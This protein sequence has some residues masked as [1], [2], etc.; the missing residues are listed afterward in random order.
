MEHRLT[1]P[2]EAPRMAPLGR[3]PVFAVAQLAL[4][5]G[6][7]WTWLATAG[8]RPGVL[9]ALVCTAPA[10]LALRLGATSQADRQQYVAR[11]LACAAMLPILLMMWAGAQDTPAPTPEMAPWVRHPWIFFTTFAVL[12]ATI[13]VAAIAWL[14]RAVTRVEAARHAAWVP[15]AVLAQRLQ[16]LAAA[17]VPCTVTA[18]ERPGEWTVALRLAAAER[19]HRVLLKIDEPGRTVRVRERL[20]ASGAAPCGC[21][22]A[23][24]RTL[25]EPICDPTRPEAQKISSRVAQATMIDP[26]RLQAT[27]LVLRDGIAE[28][29]AQAPSATAP[30]PDAVV[31]LLC[32]LVTRSGY[33]WQP[34]L[35]LG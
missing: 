10:V 8:A 13:F 4:M 20:G 21:E 19:S 11:L 2:G 18:G 34:L 15:A 30:D 3:I 29:A 9:E 27:R 32:A 26:A 6:L 23:S 1:M 25:G 28:P 12:H 22:E 35:G 24:L 7:A 14:A 33:A 31:T 16:S 17:G 5:G